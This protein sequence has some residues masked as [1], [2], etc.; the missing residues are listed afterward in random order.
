MKCQKYRYW[1]L[2]IWI[3]L[4]CFILPFFYCAYETTYLSY[5]S[6]DQLQLTIGEIK[7]IQFYLSETIIIQKM[8]AT[9]DKEVVEKKRIF[10]TEETA[11]K[12]V[13][14]PKGTPLVVTH[15]QKPWVDTDAG[16]G[17]RL[18]FEMSTLIS[19]V[20]FINDKK[21]YHGSEI[22]INGQKYRVVF[23]D[24]TPALKFTAQSCHQKETMTKQVQGQSLE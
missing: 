20:R 15:V 16:D 9:V 19:Y 3:S 8:E 10:A 11:A 6:I 14:L 7:N 22:D 18:R 13:I 12:Q 4:V 21:I 17:I 24:G 1:H 23:P 5:E 2:T